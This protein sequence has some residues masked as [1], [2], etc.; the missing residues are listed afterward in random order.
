MWIQEVAI[1]NEATIKFEVV[2]TKPCPQ[3][4]QV[5]VMTSRT[6]MAPNPC[7]QQSLKEVRLDDLCWLFNS[8][9]LD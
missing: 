4:Q 9:T 2:N 6:L 5:L 7:D 8:Y 3:F 1:E